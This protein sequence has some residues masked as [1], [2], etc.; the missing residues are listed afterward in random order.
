MVFHEGLHGFTGLN[1]PDLHHAL[2]YATVTPPPF[3]NS[4]N[5]TDYLKQFVSTPQIQLGDIRSCQ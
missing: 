2:G 4:L 3:V 5:I 1:D